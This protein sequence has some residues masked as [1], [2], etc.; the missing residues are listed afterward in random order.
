M[1]MLF[2]CPAKVRDILHSLD[3]LG[4]DSLADCANAIIADSNYSELYNIAN[5]A[6]I[7]LIDNWRILVIT[8]NL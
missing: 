1:S 2:N 3:L 7:D 6:D 8:P 5:K 4:Y